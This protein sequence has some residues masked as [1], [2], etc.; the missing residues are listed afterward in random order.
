[1]HGGVVL[2]WRV[3]PVA[4]EAEA[5][6]RAGR[7]RVDDLDVRDARA[8]DRRQRGRVATVDLVGRVGRRRG[9]AADEVEIVG[10]ALVRA[11]VLAA[12]PVVALAGPAV[13]ARV[14]G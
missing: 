12:R 8:A 9:C 6:L 5:S 11:E 1:M 13:E 7:D 4:R 2:L 10:A 14:A 3:A